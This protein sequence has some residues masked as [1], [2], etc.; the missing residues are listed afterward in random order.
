MTV[1]SA[2][3]SPERRSTRRPRR[4]A[5]VLLVFALL[6]MGCSEAEEDPTDASR[7][8]MLERLEETF[9]G[10]QSACVLDRL[11]DEAF[12]DLLADTD[13]DADAEP[14]IAYSTAVRD[15]TIGDAPEL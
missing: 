5:G 14:L 4:T 12:D 8:R 13:L 10:D 3:A 15:C 2:L 1:D 9:S 11:P 7:R 6:M